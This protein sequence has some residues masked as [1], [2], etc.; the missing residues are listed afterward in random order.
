MLHTI[1]YLHLYIYIQ[2][3]LTYFI[4]TFRIFPFVFFVSRFFHYIRLHL[5]IFKGD[6]NCKY[7]KSSVV[8]LLSF[9]F[10]VSV[11]QMLVLLCNTHTHTHTHKYIYI[12]IY[13]PSLSLLYLINSQSTF[14][15]HLPRPKS[16]V[17]KQTKWNEIK[18]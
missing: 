13:T 2:L 16:N 9:S 5:L 10:N 18:L 3:S 7:T 11:C 17:E 15:F 8:V 1:I 6:I 14:F 12:Y 4:A